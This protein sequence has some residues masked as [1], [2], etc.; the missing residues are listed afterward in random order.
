MAHTAVD[1]ILGL[2]PWTRARSGFSAD[3]FTVRPMRVRLRNHPSAIAT[4]GT[5]I[6][7]ASWVPRTSTPAT[8]VQVWLIATGYRALVSAISGSAKTTVKA[9]PAIPMVA[10]SMITLGA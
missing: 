9:T 1:T 2:I 3:A 7:T 4:S 6:S 5:T 8:L 10:T